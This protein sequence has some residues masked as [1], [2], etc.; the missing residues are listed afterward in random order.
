MNQLP[1]YVVNLDRR[2]D[3]WEAISE[4]LER[5]GVRAERVAAVDARVLAETPGWEIQSDRKRRF[6]ALDA[7]ATACILSHAATLRRF[8][9]TDRPAALVLEDDALLA[10]DAAPLLR[11]TDWWPAGA[12][13]VRLVNIGGSG[14][15]WREAT[16]LGPAGGGARTPDGRELRRLERRCESAVAYLIDRTGAGTV[17]DAVRDPDVP[18]DHILFDPTLSRTARRL[19]TYQVVPA[20]AKLRSA[21]GDSDLAPFRRP[22]QADRSARRRFRRR[23]NLRSVPLKVRLAALRALGRVRRVSIAFE[24]RAGG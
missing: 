6:L 15:N 21:P 18:Y 10:A 14:R 5:I 2:P 19:R 24:D 22:A 8:L 7:G 4:N 16:L 23:R 20:M 13:I 1:V 17:L 9:S 11:S 12:S 3:R